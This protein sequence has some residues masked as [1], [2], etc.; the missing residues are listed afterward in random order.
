MFMLFVVQGYHC[1]TFVVKRGINVQGD[2]C[3][4]SLVFGVFNVRGV[5]DVRGDS[6]YS[7][8]INQ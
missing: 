7:T 8:T 3:S 1:P 6:C 4:G 2:E 5:I